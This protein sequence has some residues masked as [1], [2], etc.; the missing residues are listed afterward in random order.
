VRPGD[1]TNRPA[2]PVSMDMILVTGGTGVLGRHVVR[3]LSG[4]EV[5]V[6]SR[7]D[8][9]VEG[10]EVVR[11]DL[12]TG[13]GIAEAVA[14][15]DVIVHAATAATD[16]RKQRSDIEATRTL[17]AAVRGEP[18]IVY[19]SIVGVDAI[20]LGLYGAKLAA[21]RLIEE[22]GLP[23][24]TLRTT[25]FHELVVMVCSMLARGPVAFV[26]R[27]IRVQPVDS[28]EV[29]GRLVDLALGAPAGR[30][31]D[32]GGPRVERFDDL[33]RAYLTATRRRR[34][35]LS[36]PIPGR[37]AAGFRAGHHL[38]P[39]HATGVRS[40]TDDL[41]TRIGPGGSFEPPYDL[42]QRRG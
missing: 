34:P 38:A 40:F 11:G 27:G 5:R 37:A 22:S 18:H 6:L 19:I 23:W 30:V 12:L 1:V 25:Q 21:E 10:A 31:P 7:R 16:F 41:V 39:D 24:T 29:A 2:A 13:E 3:R 36:V 17:L 28:D 26:P 42:K 20:P 8:T 15:V 4:A 32:M 9:P 33:M 14:G 35:V